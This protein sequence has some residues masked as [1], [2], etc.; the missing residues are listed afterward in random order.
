MA[1]VYIEA[2]RRRVDVGIERG[3]GKRSLSDDEVDPNGSHSPPADNAATAT[4]F[5]LGIDPAGFGDPL[6]A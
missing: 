4:C 1:G 2:P 3:G 6:V 5:G